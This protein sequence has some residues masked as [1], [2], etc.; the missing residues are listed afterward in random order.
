M[1]EVHEVER[2][3]E[4]GRTRS[5]PRDQVEAGDPP[6]ITGLPDCPSM[7]SHP[8][9]LGSSKRVKNPAPLGV[10]RNSSLIDPVHGAT[11]V[12]MPSGESWLSSTSGRL[13]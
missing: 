10:G 6:P 7:A 4:V 13:T 12:D 8:R 9:P 11:I 2:A 1:S 5:A 3:V